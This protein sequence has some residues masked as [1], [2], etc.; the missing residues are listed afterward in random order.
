VN[1]LVDADGQPKIAIIRP[2]NSYEKTP[3]GLPNI[4]IMPPEN[5]HDSVAS[6]PVKTVDTSVDATKGLLFLSLFCCECRCFL[7]AFSLPSR[8]KEMM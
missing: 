4:A 8:Q 1:F 5:L 6:E 7:F 2:L 3:D